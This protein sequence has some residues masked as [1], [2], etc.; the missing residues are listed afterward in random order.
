MQRVSYVTP[1]SRH[2][3][4]PESIHQSASDGLVSSSQ[5]SIH[6]PS[7]YLPYSPGYFLSCP[8]CHDACASSHLNDTP[9][10]SF[11]LVI[12]QPQHQQHHRHDRSCSRQANQAPGGPTRKK[13]LSEKRYLMVNQMEEAEPGHD[14]WGGH[15]ELLLC[16]S[17]SFQF[18]RKIQN[19]GMCVFFSAREKER[20]AG[21][22]G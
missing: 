8:F 19:L 17:L 11:P 20:E 6:P 10:P 5:P 18:T 9:I 1:L 22:H 7:I 16:L 15:S 4:C 14:S 13:S 12:S 2:Q 21:T 3:A